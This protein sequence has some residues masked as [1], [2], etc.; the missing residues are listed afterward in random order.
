VTSIRDVTTILHNGC[1]PAAP[2]RLDI[3]AGGSRRLSD[4]FEFD[5]RGPI[6]GLNASDL[7]TNRLAGLLTR[8]GDKVT[9]QKNWQELIRPNKLR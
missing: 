6:R 1:R 2:A 7:K 5:S 9:I 4:C 8:R 3:G